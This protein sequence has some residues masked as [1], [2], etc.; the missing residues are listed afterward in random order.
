M[1]AEDWLRELDALEIGIEGSY[2]RERSCPTKRYGA[3]CRTP[4]LDARTRAGAATVLR[5]VLDD[6]GRARLRVVAEATAS[7]K[8]RVAFEAASGDE[9]EALMQSLQELAIGE[10]DD[11]PRRRAREL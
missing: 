7:P 5:K 9:E 3:Q 2:R 11:Q 6:D 8:L 1:N 4:S 10:D